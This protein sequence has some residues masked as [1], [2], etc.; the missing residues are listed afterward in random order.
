[1]SKQYLGVFAFLS[2]CSS[3]L[4]QEHANNIYVNDKGD[5]YV[6]ADAPIYFFI[7]PENQPSQKVLIPSNDKAANPMYFDGDGKHF[8]VYESKGEKVRF[9]I[10]ADGLGPKS[11][12]RVE[13]GLLF[14][15]NNRVYVESKATFTVSAIDSKSGVKQSFI[16][17]DNKPF[18]PFNSNI[19]IERTGEYT[20]KIYSTDNVGNVGDTATY[21]IVA[22]PDITFKIDNIYFETASSRITGNSTDNLKEMVE[23]LKNH[24]EL[25]VEIKAHADSR[26]SSDYNLELSQRRAQSV[27]NYLTSKGIQYYRLKAKG[28]G[29]TQPVNECVK[30]VKCPDSKHR[31]NR[32]VEFRFY[33]PKK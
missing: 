17:I 9:L 13:K 8:L 16:A 18:A 30:G 2:L 26:G 7:S 25:F 32:R 20:I 6:K 33:L 27:V 4:A 19:D 31:E 21:K 28:Y 23:I 24:P 12:L 14:K 11:S 3:I 5:V 10:W 1:M 15:H 29:Y 22:A